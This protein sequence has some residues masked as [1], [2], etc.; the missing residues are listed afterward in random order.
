[1][2]LRN[3]FVVSIGGIVGSLLRWIISLPFNETDWPYG[4]LI[5]NF[6]GAGILIY[7]LRYFQLHSDPKWWWRPAIASG[8]CGGFT[9]YS[10]FAVQVQG[11]LELHKYFAAGSYVIISVAG[12][13]LIMTIISR[14]LLK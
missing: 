12:T 6:L 5:V 14:K 7:A 10:A 1:V 4:T 9:T 8:F 13:Y 2:A 11:Y 3:I